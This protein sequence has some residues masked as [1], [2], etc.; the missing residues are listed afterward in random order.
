MAAG[1]GRPALALLG[2][3]LVIA[4]WNTLRYPPG[5][6]YDAID[7]IAYAEA[8]LHGHGFP[9]GVGEYYTPPGFYAVTA[10]AI[11]LGEQIGLGE[12]LRLIQL[13]NAVLLVATAVLLLELA[14]LVF[15]SR[16]RL[17]VAALGAVRASGCWRHDRPRWCTPSRC[18]SSSRPSRSCSRRA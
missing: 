9:D 10:G 13:V 15:P 4:A 3:L 14:R 5:L 17:H 6:G 2:V 11:W 18:R 1:Y 8:I 16:R 7:H 12:P